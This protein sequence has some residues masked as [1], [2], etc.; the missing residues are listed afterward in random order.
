VSKELLA[1]IALQILSKKQIPDG[2]EPLVLKMPFNL[3]DF[4]LI[5]KAD[6]IYKVI[7]AAAGAAI[8]VTTLYTV[9]EHKIA[10]LQSVHVSILKAT[11][12][13]M[14]CEVFNRASDIIQTLLYE[15]ADSGPYS[16]PSNKTSGMHV[17]SWFPLILW[18]KESIRVQQALT[19]AETISHKWNIKRFE[20][21]DPRYEQ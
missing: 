8:P 15:T 2:E 7:S 1:L 9:P 16:W 4:K 13:N 19:A 6:D 20:Y 14:T 11:G 3:F 10:W 17:A 12:T 18:S 21:H 5:E